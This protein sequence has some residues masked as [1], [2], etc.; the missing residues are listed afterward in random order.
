MLEDTMQSANAAVLELGESDRALRGLSTTVTGVL[1]N[2]AG[3]HIFHAGD[4]RVY[5]LS[6]DFSSSSPAI[7]R[8]RG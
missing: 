8:R 1:I 5:Q 4:S 6:T 3:L 2:D 7:T